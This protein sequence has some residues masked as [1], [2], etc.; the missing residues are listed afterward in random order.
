MN[1]KNKIL[2]TGANGQLGKALQAECSL[3]NF[4]FVFTDIETLDLTSKESILENIEI[5]S[6]NIIINCSA[7]TAVDKAEDDIQAATLINEYAVALLSDICYKKSIFLIHIS[8][9]YVF[10]GHHF[11][12]YTEEDTTNPLSVYGHTKLLGEQVMIQS[13]CNGLIIRTSWL[14]STTGANFVK[15]IMKYASERESLNVVFDQ[16]GSPTYANDLAL[17]IINIIPQCLTMSN[18]KIYHYSSE[19]V[20][21]W[22]DFAKKIIEYTEITC[23]IKP[24]KSSEYKTKAH[25]P[26]YSVFDKS[27]IKTDFNIQIP[28]WQDS[29]KKCINILHG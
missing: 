5:H 10:D 15:T 9:D 18:V 3:S 11:Q 1:Q 22:Y 23:Q 21:S 29:L 27:K 13:G 24:V 26:F 4:E 2:V 16:I 7:Y 8:T 19:G 12:P 20:C 14:Y 28:Y 25:R 17:A 6:P